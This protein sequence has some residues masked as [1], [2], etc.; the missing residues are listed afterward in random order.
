MKKENNNILTREIAHLARDID[1]YLSKKLDKYNMGS[2]QFKI[3]INI[4]KNEGICQDKLA[5]KLGVDK[6]TITKSIKKLI[7]NNYVIREKD[8]K[9]KRYYK[10]YISEKGRKIHPEIKNILDKINK[11]LTLKF[12]ENEKDLFFKFIEKINKNLER[13]KNEKY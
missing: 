9:D 11:E 5:E 10:L 8:E 13:I 1:L 12:S 4:A 7:E 6:T 2:G 3:F